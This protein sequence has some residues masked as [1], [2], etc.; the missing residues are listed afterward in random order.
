MGTQGSRER[1][2]QYL[3]ELEV[4]YGSFSVN[5]TTISIPGGRY[6]NVRE[7]GPE[8][9]AYVRVRNDSSEVLHVG[10]NGDATLPGVRVAFDGDVEL[11]VRRTVTET[12]GI[13]C[14]IDGL[15]RVT[16]AGV[17]DVDDPQRETL[18]HVIV[19]FTAST[20]G[21]VLDE[22]AE[23]EPVAGPIEPVVA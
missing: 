20:T 1:I 6:E 12:T 13:E 3:S 10:E 16:I 18:Y 5:Q 9:D 11:Q 7:R 21:G 8:V 22:H 19:V 2:E 14:E 15:E 17:R 4:A 23:W